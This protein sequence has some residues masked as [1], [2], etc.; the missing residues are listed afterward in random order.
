MKYF[1]LTLLFVIL[2]IYFS[3]AQSKKEKDIEA[4]YWIKNSQKKNTTVP[5]K[6]KNES[7]VIL[8]QEYF[9]DYHKFAKNVKYTNAIRKRIKLLDQAALEEFS[10]FSFTKTFRVRRGYWGKKGTKYLGIKIIK[11]DGSERK[12]KIDNEAV[13]TDNENEYKLAISGLEIG[14][15]IDYYIHT[16]EPF[17]QKYGYSFSPRTR[18]L[19]DEY[20]AKK[21]VLKFNTEN[22]FFI[23]FNS[24]NGAPDLK[25]I[26]T[27]KNND[28][29]YE[30]IAQDVEK[31]EFPIWFYGLNELPFYKFQ[32][33]FARS[34]SY[35][36]RIFNFLS[37]KEKEIKK[38]VAPEEVLELYKDNYGKMKGE[39]DPLKDYF[40]NKNLSN[41]ELVTQAYYYLRHF[42]NTQYIEP[43]VIN[44]A[45]IVYPY[46]YYSR[47]KTY[48][49]RNSS[50]FNKKFANFL[51]EN[52]IPFDLIVVM[53][54]SNGKIKDLLY[55][56]EINSML[57]INLKEPIYISKFNE[58]STI[59]R[60]P[61]SFQNATAYALEYSYKTKRLDKISKITLEGTS[62]EDNL[63]LEQL[64]LSFNS[65]WTEITASKKSSHKGHNKEGSQDDILYYY[66]Y[67]N[68]DYKK[69]NNIN[70]FE[71]V[72]RKKDKA[73]YKKEYN[74][75]VEKIKERQKKSFTKYT[76]GE[77]NFKVEDVNIVIENTGRYEDNSAFVFIQNFKIK[78]ELIKK[79]GPNYIFE[80]GKLIGGQINLKGKERE[81]NTDIYMSYPRTFKNEISI[82]IPNGYK[83]SGIDKLNKNASND[84]ASF[85]SVAKVENGF[86]KITTTKSYYKNYFNKSKWIDLLSILDEALDF[87]NAKILFK[88]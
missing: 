77:Y 12:I 31:S 29:R 34:G 52:K 35:E 26:Q 79:A 78:N 72:K 55:T 9:Y 21:Y 46:S 5:E 64:D 32:V 45:N 13:A 38:T 8:Y 27:K 86:I 39:L 30:F 59:E 43:A 3:S 54:R 88:K 25:E 36:D 75:F 19:N 60:I 74:A 70:F 61:Y 11:P 22:D 50:D 57:R 28:R 87:S 83:V 66:D 47:E 82:A 20:P 16:I 73:K 10:E 53:P 84:I 63:S 23:N 15:I 1:Q 4:I 80:V 2:G 51:I 24:Y 6:W 48:Y 18:I 14:D 71:R 37:E 44:E 42:Y 40:K 56:S 7:A 41:K 85:N 76:N 62:A 65:D 68:E 69:Y 81:R 58:T 33:T 17:K 49:I 67:V